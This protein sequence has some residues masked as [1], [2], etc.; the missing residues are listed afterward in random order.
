MSAGKKKI[1]QAIGENYLYINES[2]IKGGVE[3]DPSALEKSVR[4][5]NGHKKRK[6]I[7]VRG[8]VQ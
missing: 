4:F 3:L 2:Q 1:K 7:L 6:Y 5:Q 8:L